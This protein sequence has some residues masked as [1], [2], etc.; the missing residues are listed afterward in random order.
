V[1]ARLY[2]LAV[3]SG[4]RIRREETILSKSDLLGKKMNYISE[5]L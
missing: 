1:T 3:A 5:A 2:N 4:G